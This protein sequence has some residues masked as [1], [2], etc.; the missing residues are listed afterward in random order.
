MQS[1]TWRTA[2]GCLAYRKIDGGVGIRWLDRSEEQW[3]ENL[4]SED[5]CLRTAYR[6]L[7]F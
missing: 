6:R 4:G 1:P 3:R 2:N 7:N 5:E